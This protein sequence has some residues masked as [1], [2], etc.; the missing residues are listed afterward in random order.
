M[1]FKAK[2]LQ[3]VS[4]YLSSPQDHDPHCSGCARCNGQPPSNGKVYLQKSVSLE[5]NKNPSRMSLGTVSTTIPL[6]QRGRI[7]LVEVSSKL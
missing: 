6:S 2:F 1:K 3:K 7:V 5:T 4:G